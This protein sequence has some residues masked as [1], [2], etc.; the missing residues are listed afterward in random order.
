[1]WHSEVSR[2]TQHIVHSM[3]R[4]LFFATNGQCDIQHVLQNTTHLKCHVRETILFAMNRARDT[5]CLSNK[6]SAGY[7]ILKVS[8]PKHC[9]FTARLWK[10]VLPA[11]KWNMKNEGMSVTS[12]MACYDACHLPSW[13]MSFSVMMLERHAEWKEPYAKLSGKNKQIEKNFPA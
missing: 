6:Y 8:M 7:D 10:V 9:V 2:K 11:L 13:C 1:M 4:I 5:R 12:C 3:S